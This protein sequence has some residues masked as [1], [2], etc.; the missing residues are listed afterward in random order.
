MGERQAKESNT[1]RPSQFSGRG[2]ETKRSVRGDVMVRCRCSCS[3]GQRHHLLCLQQVQALISPLFPFILLKNYGVSVS[4]PA[5]KWRGG[6]RLKMAVNHIGSGWDIRYRRGGKLSQ[7]TRF[8]L[9]KWYRPQ[10]Y[11]SWDPWRSGTF[12]CFFPNPLTH[13]IPP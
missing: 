6:T 9:E 7:N 4:I 2:L 8:H 10:N 11:S 3:K 5:H 13:L 12:A 1:Q